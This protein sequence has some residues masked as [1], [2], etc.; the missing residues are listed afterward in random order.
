LSIALISGAEAKFHQ[1]HSPE[2][3]SLQGAPAKRLEFI[4]NTLSTYK[5]DL[6]IPSA[7]KNI[8][9]YKYF[10]RVIE[11]WIKQAKNREQAPNREVSIEELMDRIE[12]MIDDVKNQYSPSEI[13]ALRKKLNLIILSVDDIAQKKILCERV[14][15]I[16]SPTLVGALLKYP[17]EYLLA[18]AGNILKI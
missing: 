8:S 13:D 4:Y 11:S 17:N 5:F 14:L 16:D 9:H 12:R 18:E 3:Y 6:K 2:Y 15:S 10:L 7:N 1:V